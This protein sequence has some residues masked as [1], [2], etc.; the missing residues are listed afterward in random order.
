VSEIKKAKVVDRPEI[1]L[2]EKHPYLGQPFLK[3]KKIEKRILSSVNKGRGYRGK[4]VE[5]TYYLTA[6]GLLK[7]KVYFLSF[8]FLSFFTC[9]EPDLG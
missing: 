3:K 7:N 8:L 9:F 1:G 4:A 2:T 5:T 6:K